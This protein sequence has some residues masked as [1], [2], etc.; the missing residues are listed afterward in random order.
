[1]TVEPLLRVNGLQKTYGTRGAPVVAIANVSLDVA[2]G[3]FVSVVGPSGAG[4]TTLL[5]RISGLLK[6][7]AGA[8]L[9]H[10]QPITGPPQDLAVVFQDYGRSLFPWLTVSEN[11]EMPLKEKRLTKDRRHVLVG[12]ALEAVG[13]AGFGDRYPWELSGE[14]S[15]AWP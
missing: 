13:L 3:D 10:G 12:D 11:V 7:T 8:I 5:K 14:C 15:S 4:K 1:M 9:I 2:S 6:P